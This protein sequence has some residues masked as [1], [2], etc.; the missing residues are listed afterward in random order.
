VKKAQAA[1]FLPNGN[2]LISGGEDGSGNTLDT[3]EIYNP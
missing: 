1:A 2:V 3:A